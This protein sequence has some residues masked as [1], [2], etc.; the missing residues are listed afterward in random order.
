MS[1][2]RARILVTRKLPDAVEARLQRDYD[3]LLNPDDATLSAERIIEASQHCDGILTS[4]IDR[5]PGELIRRLPARVRI[6]ATF[7][8]GFDHIDI[9][10]ARE[11]GIT[12]TNTPDVLT[13][14]TADIAILL[15]LAA[16]RRAFEGQQM[17]REDAW[18]GWR[19]TQ[20]MGIGLAGKNLGIVG[21]GRIG[22]AVARRAS[23]FGLK[24]HYHNRSRV[25]PE[26]EQGA[27]YH[28]TLETMLPLCHFLSLHCPAT[29]QT[30]HMIN[31]G[32]IGMLPKDAV[33]VN[34]AR[35][36]LVDDE[37]LIEALQSGR[38]FAAGLDVFDNEPALHPGYRGLDNC[39]LLPHL[40]SAT[41][42]ARNAMGFRCLYNLDSF[43]AGHA[44]PDAVT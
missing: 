11:K 19:P 22:A 31:R 4:A 39:Y 41:V 10:A 5:W 43:F 28:E 13:D 18:I 15:L 29:P 8:V 34:T 26:M 17:V 6:M 44:A 1:S 35:G 24:L 21:M 42:D 32:T 40:G 30:R 36:A 33:L 12:V 23:G 3:V 38:L 25:A 9:A 14:A 37:A 16:S 7:S 20:L 2:D 27:I